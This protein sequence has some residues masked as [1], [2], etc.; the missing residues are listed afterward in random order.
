[1]GERQFDLCEKWSGEGNGGWEM[2]RTGHRPWVF[3][4][5]SHCSLESRGDGPPPPSLGYFPAS[6]KNPK[7]FSGRT[8]RCWAEWS[9]G[10]TISWTK[11]TGAIQN[12][13][14]EALDR[15]TSHGEET[16]WERMGVE[17]RALEETRVGTPSQRGRGSNYRLFWAR[18]T[19]RKARCPPIPFCQAR[20]QG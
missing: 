10:P 7:R 12:S 20:G 1:M 3:V 16:V 4:Y 11:D 15:N 19:F 18:T 17:V 8:L 13:R 2:G 9:K 5:S 14:L 6:T